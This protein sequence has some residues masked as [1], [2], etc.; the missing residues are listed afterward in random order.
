MLSG[1]FTGLCAIVQWLEEKWSRRVS[2]YI[3]GHSVKKPKTNQTN[4]NQK[5]SYA[6]V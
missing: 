3:R 1:S 6:P 4:Q 2:I 5:N